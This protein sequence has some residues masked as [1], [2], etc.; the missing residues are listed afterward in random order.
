MFNSLIT[1]ESL[2]FVATVSKQ[3]QPP[4]AAADFPSSMP[5]IAKNSNEAAVGRGETTEAAQL[6]LS[7]NEGKTQKGRMKQPENQHRWEK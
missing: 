4:P 1:L 5:C 7:Y 3:I 6:F 2:P